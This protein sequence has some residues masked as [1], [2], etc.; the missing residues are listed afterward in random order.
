MGIWVSCLCST[1][2]RNWLK[3]CVWINQTLQGVMNK[4]IEMING[5]G[6][7]FSLLEFL[8]QYDKGPG[9]RGG[10]SFSGITCGARADLEVYY[11]PV[12]LPTLWRIKNN[13]QERHGSAN[14]AALVWASPH[15]STY[16]PL[17][18]WDVQWCQRTNLCLN[19]SWPDA[20]QVSKHSTS[21]LQRVW[22]W[23]HIQQA[24][25]K[26]WSW[27]SSWDPWRSLCCYRKGPKPLH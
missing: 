18:G 12:R 10:Y 27:L 20:R 26:Q 8:A 4:W 23:K 7:T 2:G 21:P 22:C 15:R 16:H 11:N 14:I 25:P 19:C 17:A 9:R 5:L 6:F 24:R 1:A 13:S 3:V